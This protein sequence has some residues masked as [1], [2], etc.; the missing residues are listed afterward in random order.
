MP[1]TIVARCDQVPFPNSNISQVW[2]VRCQRDVYDYIYG[3]DRASGGPR[4]DGEARSIETLVNRAPVA[5][6]VITNI[7]QPDS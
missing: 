7:G 1:G 3:S 2:A 4:Q 5:Q 6:G